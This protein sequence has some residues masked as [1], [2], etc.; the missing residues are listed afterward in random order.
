M[1]FRLDVYFHQ[2][3]DPPQGN[4]LILN[5]LNLISNAL[6]SLL[7]QGDQILMDLSDLEAAVTETTT[8]QASAVLLIQEI[9][10]AILNAAGDAAKVT[11]LAQT[12]RT[13]AAALGDAVAANTVTPPA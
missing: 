12:L 11:E 9:A 4:Q 3:D 1:R 5:Q 8:V 10:A 6:Q 2:G 7:N 13:S